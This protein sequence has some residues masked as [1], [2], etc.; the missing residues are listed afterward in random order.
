MRALLVDD[1]GVVVEALTAALRAMRVF[2]QID[3][4]SSFAQ[5]QALLA[6]NPKCDLAILD[7]DLSDTQGSATLSAFREAF[8]DVPVVVFSAESSLQTITQAFECG[9]RGYVPKRS[10]MST[11]TAAIRVVLDGNAYVPP[12]AISIITATPSAIGQPI[13]NARPQQLPLTGRQLQVF[14][15]LL[16]GKSN[17]VIAARLDMAEGTAKAHLNTVF[18]VLGVRTR[19]EAILR[20]RE[21]GLG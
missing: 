18:R 20:A 4:A 6:A 14:R 1:H 5:A 17:K 3:S 16:E 9:A 8:P 15:L 12:E 21:M 10:S 2:N 11:V 7:L 19:V 13:G